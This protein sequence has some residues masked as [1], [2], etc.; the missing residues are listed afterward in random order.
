MGGVRRRSNTRLTTLPLVG[1]DIVE[2]PKWA[3]KSKQHLQFRLPHSKTVFR[4]MVHKTANSRQESLQD[5][6]RRCVA[7]RRFRFERP[8][9]SEETW[10]LEQRQVS[11]KVRKGNIA[12]KHRGH[13]SVG[14]LG[15]GSKPRGKAGAALTFLAGAPAIKDLVELVQ[16]IGAERK[17]RSYR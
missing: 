3:A 15:K 5:P 2:I 17:T 12:A 4:A 6:S 8:K 16:N 1:S 9:S 13:H 11:K 7:R 10:P 14:C